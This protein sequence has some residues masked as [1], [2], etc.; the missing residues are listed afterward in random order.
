MRDYAEA[1]VTWWQEGF[2]PGD[3][4]DHV[5]QRIRKGPPAL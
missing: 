5:R 3:T 2:L 4:P 1:G